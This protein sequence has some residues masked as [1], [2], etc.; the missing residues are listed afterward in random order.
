MRGNTGGSMVAAAQLADLFLDSQM[1]VRT[2]TRDGPLARRAQPHDRATPTVLFDMPLAILVDPQTASAAEI[3]SGA[4]EPLGN[5]TLVGQT[6]F[7]KGLV[8][9]VHADEGREPAEADGRGVP[10]LGRPRDQ[11]EGHRAGRACCSRCRSRGSARSRTCRPS[12]IPYVRGS[13]DDDAFPVDVGAS[14]LRE[15]REQAL[16]GVR[17]RSYAEI[18]KHLAKLGVT[19]SAQRVAGDPPL[20][21]PLEIVAAGADAGRRAR[22]ASCEITVT[23]PNDFALRRRVGRARGARRST[24]TTRSRASGTLAAPARPRRSS[25]S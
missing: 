16:A 20:A 3:I 22:P 11:Q 6:T 25:S 7:G 14:L 4:L 19:W 1:I 18:A 23:N 12:A 21:K 10:A 13:G 5:V 9:Q 24:S 8:Q 17:K 2:V 15:P